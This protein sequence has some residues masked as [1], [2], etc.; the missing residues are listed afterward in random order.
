MPWSREDLRASFERAGD[1]HWQ[2][3]VRHHEDAY[4]NPKPTPGTV[5][6]GEADRLNEAG[7]GDTNRYELLGSYAERA[8]PRLRL[9]HRL[10][11]RQSGQV[12]ETEPF[13]NYE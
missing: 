3:L 11:D 8:G 12:I 10:R 13:E 6:R 4:P 9:V 5:C 7:F 1:E 2:A